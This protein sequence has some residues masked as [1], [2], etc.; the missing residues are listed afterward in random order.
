[1]IIKCPIC[2]TALSSDL[3]FTHE[4]FEH[5]EEAWGDDCHDYECRTA[6]RKGTWTIH[7]SYQPSS[8]EELGSKEFK[9]DKNFMVLRL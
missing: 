1:M 8:N 6:V 7:R 9:V 2:Q 5:F 4:N 3:H